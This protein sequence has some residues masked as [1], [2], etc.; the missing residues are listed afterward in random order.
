[1]YALC[2]A[3]VICECRPG[4]PSDAPCNREVDIRYRDQCL[5]DTIEVLAP[6]PDIA[7]K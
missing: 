6:S 5:K 7:S 1:M 3:K 4:T 2:E